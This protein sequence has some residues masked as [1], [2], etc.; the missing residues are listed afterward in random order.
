MESTG[1]HRPILVIGGTGKTGRH[2]VDRLRRRGKEVRALSRS[3]P[4]PFDWFDESTWKT[5]VSG[6]GAAYLVDAQNEHAAERMRAFAPFAVAQGVERLVLLSARGWADSGDPGMLATEDA[7]RDSGGAWTI[8]RPTWFMQGFAED[9]LM[10]APVLAGEVRL[11]AGDGLEPF[12]DTEDIAETAAAVLTR[13]GDEGCTYEL[14]GPRALTLAEAVAAIAEASGRPV[15]YVPVSEEEYVAGLVA[16][17]TPEDAAR[18]VARL[19]GWLRDGEDAHLSDGVQRVL[20]RAP[21][22]LTDFVRRAA[23]AGAWAG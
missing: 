2:V 13:E 19:W 15:R 6:A 8:L 18:F 1:G 4:V 5:A 16:D 3:T 14:S 12:I 17:G 23:A 11:P 22:D 9:D 10:R 7:V 21:G 20:G